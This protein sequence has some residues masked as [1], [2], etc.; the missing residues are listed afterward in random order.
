MGCQ[1]L[2]AICKRDI[3]LSGPDTNTPLVKALKE[4]SVFLGV[5]AFTVIALTIGMLLPVASTPPSAELPWQI[6][7]G[8]DGMRVFGLTLGHSSLNDA[9]AKFHEQA[10]IS[11]FVS[12]AGQL[13]AEAYFDQVNLGGLRAKVVLAAS[14]TQN[15][16]QD[17]YE[18]GIRI[19]GMS[20]GRKI[21]LHP[22]DKA[23]VLNAAIA[24][25]NYLPSSSLEE[26]VLV[27]RFGEPR[28]RVHEEKNEILHLL[29]PQHGLDIALNAKNKAVFQYV[30]PA[31]FETLIAPLLAIQPAK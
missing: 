6:E 8:A 27:Q 31:E 13:A 24:S 14:L 1:A 16:L 7:Q 19:S 17:M 10:E 23:R 22:D 2:R 20:S 9:Q 29:Y 21:E 26:A 11:L 25:I 3:K 12:D 30:A 28:R 5:I 15:Q 4:Y 18:R